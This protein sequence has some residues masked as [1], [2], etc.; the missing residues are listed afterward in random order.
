MFFFIKE[1]HE[2]KFQ[3]ELY[4]YCNFI[5]FYNNINENDLI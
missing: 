2:T 1:A 4:E 5:F 3:K